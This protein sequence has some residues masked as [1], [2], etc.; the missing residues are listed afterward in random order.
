MARPLVSL[1]LALLVLACGDDRDARE[2]P[3]P[4]PAP[5]EPPET[6]EPPEASLPE[7]PPEP[8]PL[9]PARALRIAAAD[10]VVVVGDLRA[11][12]DDPSAPLVVLVHQLGSARGE[13]VP[14]LRHLG[15]E[16]ALATF[17]FDM[18]GH[19]ESTLGPRR[20]DVRYSTFETADWARVATDLRA[21][22]DHLLG[23]EALAPRR[24]LF[25]GSSIGS[26]AVVLAAA[27][28]PR[29][30]AIALLSPG[31]AYRGV[32]A[33]TPLTRL[34][35]R[36]LLAIASR[37]EA[38]AAE[39]AEAMGRIAPEGDAVLVEGDRHGVAMFERD[40][41]SLT[42]LVAFLRHQAN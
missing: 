2:E 27:E 22:L 30:H 32:D 26:S 31:R 24:V 6:L 5:E 3:R 39:T 19:G 40:P 12:A 35:D 14:V 13:W 15:A 18:R 37:Q 33:L 23:E 21:V 38:P 25:V 9:A 36:P 7:P 8:P 1:G 17:A 42:R 4:R 10:G 34:G 16:P 11:P 28:D 29:V 20:R 41:T